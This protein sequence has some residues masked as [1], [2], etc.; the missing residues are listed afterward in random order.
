M[1]CTQNKTIMEI[2]KTG[3][4]FVCLGNICRSPAAESVMNKLLKEKHRENEFIIDSCGIGP[5]H[6]GQ[7]SDK[8]MIEAGEKRGYEFNH[9]GRQIDVEDFDKFEYI[10]G[11]DEENIRDI[12]SFARNEEDRKKVY[13]MSSFLRRY[14]G[15]KTIPDP[16]FGG[17]EGFEFVLDLLEDATEGL[18]IF[19][20][21]QKQ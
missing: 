20:D 12:L 1:C 8:R 13:R 2:N 21:K 10:I 3:L 4:L 17:T 18:L 6:V 14:K 9:R 7:R 15:Q 16:Y 19:L 11:M 5:W